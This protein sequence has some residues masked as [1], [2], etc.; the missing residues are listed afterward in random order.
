MEPPI[1]TDGGLPTRL[2]ME[3]ALAQTDVADREPK[4]GP[5]ETLVALEC[6]LAAT[7]PVVIAEIGRDG[8]GG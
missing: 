3:Q 2:E 6:P 7:L 8:S 5:D 4:H 1:P